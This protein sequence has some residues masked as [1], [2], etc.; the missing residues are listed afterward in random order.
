MSAAA[1]DTTAPTTTI[2]KRPTKLIEAQ[3]QQVGVKF[4]FSSDETGSA[5]ECKLDNKP[6]KPCSSPRRYRIKATAD[7]TK[8]TFR[9]VAID[10]AGNKDATPAKR[11]FKVERLA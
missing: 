1:A 3:Q 9:V 8:H 11:S 2:T 4:S 5:F 10:L 6:F 7:A